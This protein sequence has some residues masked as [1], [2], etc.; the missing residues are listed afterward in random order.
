MIKLF[1]SVDMN[2]TPRLNEIKGDFST[3]LWTHKEFEVPFNHDIVSIEVDESSIVYLKTDEELSNHFKNIHNKQYPEGF[4][5][6]GGHSLI[7]YRGA[8]TILNNAEL[9]EKARA[10]D[11]STVPSIRIVITADKKLP[12]DPWWF[13]SESLKNLVDSF[14]PEWATTSYIGQKVNDKA[15]EAFYIPTVILPV[16]LALEASSLYKGLF[17]QLS[18]LGN[19]V[20]CFDN[21]TDWPSFVFNAE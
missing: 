15:F 14:A 13:A 3:S 7:R 17:E 20:Q 5:C 11:L 2:L 1:T 4:W 19:T 9:V 8:I 12:T 18:R 16:R 6:E 10:H 21:T